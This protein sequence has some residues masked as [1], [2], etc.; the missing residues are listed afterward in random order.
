MIVDRI[1]FATINAVALRALPRILLR[2]LPDGKRQGRE[3]VAKNPTRADRTLGSFSINLVTG[4]WADFATD[5]RG[6]GVISLAAYLFR[7]SQPEAAHFVAG[8][9]GIREGQK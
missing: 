5:D 8:M 2:W 7:L 9:L 4:K 6:V 1:N 3:F